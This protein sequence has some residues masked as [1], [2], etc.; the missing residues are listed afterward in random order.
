MRLTGRTIFIPAEGVNFVQRSPCAFLDE[1]NECRSFYH[2]GL[3]KI[4]VDRVGEKGLM[5]PMRYHSLENEYRGG[6]G[7][8]TLSFPCAQEFSAK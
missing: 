6:K 4:Y 5:I 3:L 8:G 1:S 7:F 2:D